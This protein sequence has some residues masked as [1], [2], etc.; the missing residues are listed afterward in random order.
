MLV[1]RNAKYYIKKV[2]LFVLTFLTTTLAGAEWISGKFI[3]FSENYRWSDFQSGMS[4]SIPFL[5]ILTV[6]EFGHYFTAKYYKVDVTLP[7]YLPMWLGFIGLPS[8]GTFG[9]LIR[10][11]GPIRSRKQFFDIGIAGPIAGFVVALGVLYYGFTHLPEPEYIFEIHPEYAEYGLDYAD[12]VYEDNEAGSISLGNNLLFWLF[13]T[14]VADPAKVPNHHEAIHY[15]VL[16]AG[17]LALFFTAL[18]LIPVGQ[19]DGGHVIYGLF[20]AKYHRIIAT[21]LFIAFAAIVGFGLITV[22]VP[23]QS[24]VWQSILYVGFLFFCFRGL[25]LSTSNT[26]LLAVALFVAQYIASMWIRPFQSTEIYL[27]FLFLLGRFIGVRH[28]VTADERPLSLGRKIL[29]WIALIIFILCFT[30]SPLII[31]EPGV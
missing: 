12:H 11:V 31:T 14:Y 15:P 8:I 9:A 30:P 13:E 18:N 10:I 4:F 2:V 25:G 28:P 26:L 22:E 16:F 1:E 3:F 5:L 6:H 23:L 7:N 20:G 21:T 27:V 19:L 24:L 29:G 17:F